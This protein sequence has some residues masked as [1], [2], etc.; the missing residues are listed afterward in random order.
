MKSK[1]KI[2]IWSD[3]M[4]PFCYIG[5]RRIE[6]ALAEFEHNDAVEI[7][8]N[9]FQLTSQNLISKNEKLAEHLAKKYQQNL[10]WA[11]N[12]LNSITQNAKK[13][14]LDLDLQEVI[15]ENSF[16]AHRLLYLAK[17]KQLSNELEELLFKAYLIDGK[18]INDTSTLTQ[19]ALQ[20]GLD[21]NEIE[22]VL[23][24]TAYTK[25][26]KYEI[27]LANNIGIKTVP[28][29]VFDN[30][31]A[32]AGAQHVATFKSTLEKTWSEGKFQS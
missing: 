28:F 17:K 15:M 30:K 23:Y 16:N 18:N 6:T 13:T 31:Y 26:V 27:Q 1:L 3:I 12:K 19:L 22:Y 11:H 2:Q 21:I 25:Q 24:T 10:E 7:E 9:S 4:C 20:V 29:F 32:I 8:W 14:G 5:K